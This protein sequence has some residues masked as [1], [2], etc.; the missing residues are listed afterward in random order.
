MSFD[1]DSYRRDLKP[2]SGERGWIDAEDLSRLSLDA[3]RAENSVV[4]RVTSSGSLRLTGAG[5]TG[6]SAVM[7]DVADTMRH[8]QRLV[9]ATGLAQAGHRS[10]RGQPSPDVVAKTK[11]KLDGAP[12]PGSLV[13]AFVPSVAPM[14][15]LTKNGHEDITNPTSHQ[16]V[17]VAVSDAL[18]LLNEA[19]LLG[20]DADETNFL[21]HLTALGPRV[22]STLRDFT[23]TLVSSEFEPEI[24]WM[25][26]NE[27]ALRS[28]L[29]LSQ[30]SYLQKI[31]T[32]RELAK[33]PTTVVGKLRTVSDI[34]AWKVEIEDGS[35]VSI[36]AKLISE[37]EVAELRLGTTVRVHATVT[38]EVGPSGEGAAKYVATSVEVV[39]SNS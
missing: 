28:R 1:W 26:P 29:T 24:R 16:A 12:M 2:R 8:F 27:R 17:D 32:S 36:V 35:I 15:E 6:H 5:V 19:Q 25:K 10:L 11:L 20:P 3:M 4:R 31:V 37:A 34:S 22:A 13:L 14:E 23:K 38:E 30:L 7:D 33:E 39:D 9:L 21:G 18:G